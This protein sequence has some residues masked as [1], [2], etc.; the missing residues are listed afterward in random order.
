LSLTI[1]IRTTEER[2]KKVVQYVLQKVYDNG[3]IYFGSYGGYYCFGCE[4]YFTEKEMVDGNAPII[5]Q[6]LN[7]FT[8]KIISLK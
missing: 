5:R 6:N 1:L 7:I 3:D 4:R 2:H 8:K